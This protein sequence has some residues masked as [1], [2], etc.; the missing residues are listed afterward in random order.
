[1]TDDEYFVFLQLKR[2]GAALSIPEGAFQT[3]HMIYL[4]ISDDLND[5]PKLQGKPN[6]SHVPNIYASLKINKIKLKI[7]APKFPNHFQRVMQY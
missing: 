4:A 6:S 5:S 7:D 2:S 3:S 1:M